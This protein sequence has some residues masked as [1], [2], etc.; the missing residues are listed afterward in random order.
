MNELDEIK[1]IVNAL[2]IINDKDAEI[3]RDI[4][5][6]ITRPTPIRIQHAKSMI[7]HHCECKIREGFSFL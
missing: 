2:K 7:R 6:M 3:L 4:E 1:G 5:W